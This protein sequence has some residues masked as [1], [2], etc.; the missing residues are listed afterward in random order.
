MPRVTSLIVS[1]SLLAVMVLPVSTAAPLT[2]SN[3]ADI[4]EGGFRSFGVRGQGAFTFSV[5]VVEGGHVDVY[6]CDSPPTLGTIQY[7]EGYDYVDVEYVEDS[8]P[9]ED[10]NVM[11]VVVENGDNVGSASEGD[12]RVTVEW[13]TEKVDPPDDS[14]AVLPILL[15]VVFFVIVLVVAMVMR[16]ARRPPPEVVVEDVYVDER[17]RRIAPPRAQALSAGDRWCP[18]CGS[19]RLVDPATGRVYCPNCTPPPPPPG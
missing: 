18:R 2:G 4:D 14:M 16:I 7:V 12:V 17:G 9:R 8:F 3:T 15:I 10:D 13:A 5:L 1:I 6:V 19:E 11:Y